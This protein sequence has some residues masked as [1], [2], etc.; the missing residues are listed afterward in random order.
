MSSK[1]T[2]FPE[3]LRD[4][5]I[6]DALRQPF[7]DRGLAHPRLADQH[8]VVL[9]PALQDLDDAPDFVVAPDHRIEFACASALQ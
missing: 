5:A 2:R 1:S 4:F 6:D 7:D 9:G 8:R 3:R